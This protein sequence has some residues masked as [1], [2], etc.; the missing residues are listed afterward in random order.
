MSTTLARERAAP[1]P[2]DPFFYGFRYVPRPR[3][4]GGSDLEMVPL[5]LEDILHPQ[6]DDKQVIGSRPDCIPTKSNSA[7]ARST[8][9]PQFPSHRVCCNLRDICSFDPCEGL[10]SWMPQAIGTRC[11]AD[12]GSC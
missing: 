9:L 7:A 8:D 11:H 1:A 3:P 4:D 10:P 5:T 2:A 12:G 6:E